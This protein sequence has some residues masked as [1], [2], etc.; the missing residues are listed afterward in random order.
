MDK[1][2]MD[3]FLSDL[4]KYHILS[5]HQQENATALIRLSKKFSKKANID[6]R[7]IRI[8]SEKT[9]VLE[10][11][12]QPNFLPHAGTWKKAFLLN[13]VHER[14]Q[15][16]GNQS[17]AFF[18]FA[19]QNISTA[20][21]LPKNQIPD[22][23]KNGFTKIGFR[24]NDEDKRRSFNKVDKPSAEQ[25]QTE[26]DRIQQHYHRISLKT[27]SGDESIKEQWDQVLDIFWTSYDR[28]ENFAEMNSVIFARIC[29]DL[30]D[31]NLSFFLYSDM[32]H[33]KLFLEESKK[34]LRNVQ[35]FN[36]IYNEE[37]A[38]NN[39]EIPPVL[40]N[41]LPFWYECTCGS[42]L[43]LFLDASGACE[44]TCPSCLKQY[45]LRFDTGFGN[46][47]LYY[48]NMDFNA[49]SRNI[50]MANGLGDTLFLSGT[51][52]SAVYGRISDRI[53]TELGFH[54]P[55]ALAWQSKDHYLGMMQK[56]VIWELMKM[57]S[58]TLG[59]FI[60]SSLKEKI[61]Q[62]FDTIARNVRESEARNNPKD[63]KYWN[64][65]QNSAKNLVEYTQKIFS[66]TPSFIDILANFQQN[67]IIQMWEKAIGSAEV[68]KN[69]HMYRIHAD[70]NYPVNFLQDV[71]PEDLPA[72]YESIKNPGV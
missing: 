58:V 3:T 2:E 32:H 66:T 10:S 35:Q 56:I 55:L 30:F 46:L 25:W 57:F 63:I 4:S 40:P 41:H 7:E 71:T 45:H 1:T 72:L 20:R 37:I 44:I 27:K 47:D 65:M 36:Q 23:N 34:I 28:A 33:E 54:R 70:I 22:L 13:Q 8:E 18:G 6:Q 53:S 5:L 26:I 64:G 24:I 60:H 43:D 59:D 51:G 49:V 15:Q 16:N 48:E 38:R 29:R 12:H 21:L 14:L 68:Q 52:G 31:I 62:K 39:L 11:G 69:G 50:I 42:K 61:E 9:I 67:T 19:D 17:V